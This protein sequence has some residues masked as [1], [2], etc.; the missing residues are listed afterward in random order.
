MRPRNSLS[1]MCIM[2]PELV[3]IAPELVFIVDPDPNRRKTLS[4]LVRAA[5]SVEVDAYASYDDL[6]PALHTH[7]AAMILS[8][9]AEG[10][11]QI[12][13]ERI[14]NSTDGDDAIPPHLLV[15][16]DVVTSGRIATARR[17]GRTELI[18]CE[19]LNLNALRNRILLI[20]EGPA[21][22]AAR[23]TR[24]GAGL[25]QALE[26]LP[27]LRKRL[28]MEPGTPGLAST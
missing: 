6:L 19:P 9:W 28:A 1:K 8:P 7:R 12:L 2:A 23:L 17:A 5:T 25:R 10:G 18:P 14:E 13:S 15:L 20:L 16:T 21:T 4:L 3:F 24:T 26:T 27:A 22:L 11:E